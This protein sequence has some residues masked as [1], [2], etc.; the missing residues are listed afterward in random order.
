MQVVNSI[1][2]ISFLKVQ[3]LQSSNYT[4]KEYFVRALAA[5]RSG[6]RIRLRNEK[7]Q[8]QIPARYK[9]FRET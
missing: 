8:V 7:A 2:L 9:V 3:N 1:K 6:H 5:W 4:C